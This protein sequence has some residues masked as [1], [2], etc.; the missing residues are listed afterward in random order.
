MKTNYQTPEI[1]VLLI[2]L[3]EGACAT[4]S[5]VENFNYKEGSWNF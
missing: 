2:S 5:A 1:E 3:E 4:T